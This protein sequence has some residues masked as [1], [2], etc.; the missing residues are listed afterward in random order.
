MSTLSSHLKNHPGLKVKQAKTTNI[1]LLNIGKFRFSFLE[2]TY[3]DGLATPLRGRLAGVTKNHINFLNIKFFFKCTWFQ[4]SKPIVKKAR[5]Q[6][7][8]RGSIVSL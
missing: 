1:L 5:A 6:N 2:E 4:G 3:L 8:P 7:G